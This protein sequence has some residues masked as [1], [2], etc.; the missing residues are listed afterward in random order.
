M[1]EDSIYN[2]KIGEFLPARFSTLGT[3]REKVK[4]ELK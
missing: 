2:A 4:V 1:E 3:S